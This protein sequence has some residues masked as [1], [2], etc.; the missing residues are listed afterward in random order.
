MPALSVAIAESQ[1]HRPAGASRKEILVKIGDKKEFESHL[2]RWQSNSRALDLGPLGGRADLDGQVVVVG[3]LRADADRFDGRSGPEV[4]AWALMARMKGVDQQDISVI[5]SPWLLLGL[6]I[7]YSGL[8]AGVFTL[9]Y[10]RVRICQRL[11]PLTALISLIIVSALLVSMVVALYGL[12]LIYAQIT[13]ILFG[14]CV[15]ILL[16]WLRAYE[17]SIRLAFER[18]LQNGNLEVLQSYDV[19][20]SYSRDPENLR[21]VENE[22]YL[23]LTKITKSDGSPLKV[24]FD[25]RSIAI[26]IWWYRKLALAIEGSQCFVAVYSKDYFEKPFCRS[27][28]HMAAIKGARVPGFILPISRVGTVEKLPQEVQHINYVDISERPDFLSEIRSRVCH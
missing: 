15:A 18:D 19:F 25:K 22:L 7:C 1:F 8:T 6:L 4:V 11:I 10:H 13:L 9:L 12:N 20:I 23:P 26:G 5:N 28:L 21:W 27:E 17:N 16:A 2:L 14:I 24:F 3:S